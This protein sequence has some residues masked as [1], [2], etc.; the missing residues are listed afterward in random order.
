MFYSFTQQDMK[1]LA[2]FCLAALIVSVTAYIIGNALP[3]IIPF[4]N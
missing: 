1:V 3:P 2:G 4:A